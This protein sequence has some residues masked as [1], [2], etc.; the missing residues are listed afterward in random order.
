MQAYTKVY[1]DLLPMVGG[2]AAVIYGK[3]L[4]FCGED[5]HCTITLQYLA[6]LLGVSEDTVRRHIKRLQ[7]CHLIEYQCGR[8]KSKAGRFYKVA[9]ILP[10]NNTAKGCKN[11]AQKVAKL[12]G[13]NNKNNNINNNSNVTL[14]S[15]LPHTRTRD[16]KPVKRVIF[17]KPTLQ[18]VMEYCESRNNGV[19]AQRFIDY[20]ESNGWMVGRNHM[21]DWRAAVRTWE[22]KDKQQNKHNYGR[23]YGTDAREVF[24]AVGR[25]LGL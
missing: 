14:T 24:A 3:V 5:D 19:N 20:Y 21:K 12:Q 13:S 2:D 22:Q 1:D 18:E 11:A 4:A 9:K 16:E 8:G 23:N 17:R 7:N 15:E 25:D 10:Y 6:D